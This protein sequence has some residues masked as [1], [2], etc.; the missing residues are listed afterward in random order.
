MN[1]ET[2]E[3]D[4]DEDIVSAFATICSYNDKQPLNTNVL[5][6]WYEK[7]YSSPTLYKL[8]LVVHGVP[9]TQVT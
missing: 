8:A 9:A 6:Y 1:H 7:R 5:E 2:E 3:I 4:E